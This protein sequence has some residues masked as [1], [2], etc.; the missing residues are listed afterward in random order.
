[1]NTTPSLQRYAWLSV[2]AALA[3]MAI[4]LLAWWWTGSVG[5]L[6]DAL[7][8]SINLIAAMLAVMALRFAERPAD[9]SHPYG[10]D[11]IEY[12]ASGFEG[13]LVM[14]A[15]IGIG[16]AAV[17]RLLQPQPLQAVDL[18]L[19]LTIAASAIN[20]VVGRLLIRV[21]RQHRSPTLE[22]DGH[23]L[24]TDVWTSAVVLVALIGVPLT[25][26]LWLDPVIALLMAGHIFV[27][28]LLLMRRSAS[29][30]LDEALDEDVQK[31]LQAVL[32]K[33]TP[34]PLHWHALR[35]RR[36]GRRAYARV[37]VLVPGVWTMQQAHDLAE[38]IEADVR[39]L[40]PS[41]A[42]SIHL[43]PLEDDRAHADFELLD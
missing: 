19:L 11:K 12:F 10:H 8:S 1:M 23:H 42:L 34:A 35:T 32:N 37:H 36:S 27:T 43:E 30:L 3:T 31:Q 38:R 28:G 9:R 13:G 5:L 41:L 4:K 14:L 24:M 39:Q 7:E 25:G 21:G 29:G 16:W 15:A 2:V 6:S 26:W 33:H 18:G 20:L 17:D 40:Q 22:A